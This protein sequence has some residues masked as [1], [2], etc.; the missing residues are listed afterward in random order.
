[1]R[2]SRLIRFCYV[3]FVLLFIHF[4]TTSSFEGRN[5]NTACSNCHG[6]NAFGT[7]TL[8]GLPT[9]AM[10]HTTYSGQICIDDPVNTSGRAGFRLHI[11]QGTYINLG[12]GVRIGGSGADEGLTHEMPKSIIDGVACW[13]F[14]WTAPASGNSN[15]QLYGNAA[16]GD[17]A[18]NSADQGG[19]AQFAV[20]ETIE[21]CPQNLT[22]NQDPIPTDI[23]QAVDEI[24]SSGVVNPM[25]EV[26]FQAGNAIILENGFHA[27]LNSTFSAVIENCEEEL[28][29]SV[30]TSRNFNRFRSDELAIKVQPNPFREVS[31]ILINVPGHKE[32]VIAK[33]LDV[34]GRLIKTLVNNT[35]EKGWQD[36]ELNRQ[37]MEKGFYFIQVQTKSISVLEKV[38]LVD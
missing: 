35:F 1:M 14:D 25:T 31:T 22:I 33:V 5:N 15:L 17:G 4:L 3:A 2:L 23:Y 32:K 28:N 37:N 20:I 18:N 27:K 11:S 21:S 29:T 19:Y 6:G 36:I 7:I 10:P 13:T 8:T 26:S 12:L 34:N 24:T 16:N 38:L 30:V 9:Q